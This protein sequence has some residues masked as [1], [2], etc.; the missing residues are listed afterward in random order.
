MLRIGISKSKKASRR[1]TSGGGKLPRHILEGYTNRYLDSCT[2][3]ELGI[4]LG[5][6][7][8]ELDFVKLQ[9][10]KKRNKR[11][12]HARKP[13]KNRIYVPTEQEKDV[14]KA[15]DQLEREVAAIYNTYSTP[16]TKRIYGE[17]INQAIEETRQEILKEIRE[18]PI[19]VQA[20]Y[21]NALSQISQ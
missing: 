16:E 7:D 19:E 1:R 4:I 21:V 13:K 5:V 17:I 20:K 2:D 9:S 11:S 8:E 15:I 12:K 3:E 10:R 6:D 14:K 18:L